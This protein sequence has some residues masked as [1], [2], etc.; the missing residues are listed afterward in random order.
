MNEPEPAFRPPETPEVR[1][2]LDMLIH[3]EIQL[4]DRKDRVTQNLLTQIR[5]TIKHHKYAK[6]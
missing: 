1:E 3:E 4:M 6:Y 2:P 5:E